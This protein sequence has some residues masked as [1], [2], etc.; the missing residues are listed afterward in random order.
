MKRE[1]ILTLIVICFSF[2]A[3]SYLLSK[4]GAI[5]A[6]QH[7][8]MYL[9]LL[10]GISF[11]LCKRL[12]L[13]NTYVGT[14]WDWI[15]GF[16][17]CATTVTGIWFDQG[18]SYE[19]MGRDVVS[20]MLCIFCLIPLFKCIFTELYL[21]MGRLADKETGRKDSDSEK[22]LKVY[23]FS[24]FIIFGFWLLVWLAY[25]PGLWNYDPYQVNEFLNNAYN[26]K[27]PLIHTLFLGS[28]YSLGLQWGDAKYGVIL[29]D[30][31]QMTIMAGIFAY[32][33]CYICKHIGNRICRGII[34]LFYAVF[35]ANPVMAISTTKD[36]IF[37]G[38]VLLCAVLTLQIMEIVAFHGG[39]TYRRKISLCVALLIAVP[40]MLLY[41]N[42][43]VYAFLVLL[44]CCL[45]AG[46]WRKSIR[47]VTVFMC[48]CLL[49]FSVEK[50]FLN[51]MLDPKP[52][53]VNEFLS[54]PSQQFGRIY[55]NISEN[56]DP[57]TIKLIRKYFN[58]EE[59]EYKPQLADAMKDG[60]KF[61]NKGDGYQFLPNAFRLFLKYPI[62]TVDAFLYLTEGYWNIQDVSFAS[63]YDIKWDGTPNHRYG[64][65]LTTIKPDYGIVPDSKLPWLL[66]FMEKLVSQNDY[67]KIPLLPILFSPALYLW[68]LAV[69]T[70]V[71]LKQRRWGHLMIAG[72]LW[73]LFFTLLLGPCVLVRY[74]Y[75]FMII[76]PVLV[77]MTVGCYN[78]EQNRSY[79]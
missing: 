67:Q 35:P 47:R 77:C 25:Y 16:W 18:L 59:Q 38:L 8:M 28:C 62:I 65:L 30:L 17:L 50:S 42:N 24:F 72:F 56:E 2:G 74:V 27:H 10:A 39:C 63:I 43:A 21:L 11:I 53:P 52:G 36:V 29:Y 66:D 22:S 73:L 7:S 69:T 48:V 37:S 19:E 40:V 68:V 54:V 13:V 75:P 44:I 78:K 46:I 20:Y 5:N 26:K 12:F 1:K 60:L 32:T 45:F 34:L 4:F 71:F 79:L 23:V 3:V 6:A 9:L 49:L 55:D 33:Y 57:E 31:I 14:K 51:T 58:M 64:Y 61:E 76:S 15:L 41:R 70:P